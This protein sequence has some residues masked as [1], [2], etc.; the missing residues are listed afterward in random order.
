MSCF[1]VSGQKNYFVAKLQFQQLLLY[2]TS[3]RGIS[4]DQL[5]T[6]SSCL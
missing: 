1:C 6:K 5:E 3:W 4:R 2:N